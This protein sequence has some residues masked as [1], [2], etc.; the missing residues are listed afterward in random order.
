MF[1]IALKWLDH[2]PKEFQTLIRIKLAA[3]S[4]WKR[5]AIFSEDFFT[6]IFYRKRKSFW[7][8]YFAG[9]C[10]KI[11]LWPVM[12]IHVLYMVSHRIGLINLALAYP[13]NVFRSSGC[14]VLIWADVVWFWGRVIYCILYR[15]H[16]SVLLFEKI[17]NVM[18]SCTWKLITLEKWWTRV[19]LKSPLPIC[20]KFLDL[21]GLVIASICW[22]IGRLDLIE[23]GVGLHRRGHHSYSLWL[24]LRLNSHRRLSK[25]LHAC[26]TPFWSRCSCIAVWKEVLKALRWFCRAKNSHPPPSRILG[27]HDTVLTFWV[28]CQ[29]LCSSTNITGNCGYV[30]PLL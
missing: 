5:C 1:L 28:D 11:Q 22:H 20:L 24:I 7:S 12:M 30:W 6:R 3:P 23:R 26:F 15:L 18:V 14:S 27:S 25:A 13:S 10:M 8:T 4:E 21:L 9:R 29:L 19:L 16:C 2:P 17:I